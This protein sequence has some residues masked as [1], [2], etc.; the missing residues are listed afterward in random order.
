MAI[1]RLAK[2]DGEYVLQYR[3]YK[4]IDRNPWWKPFGDDYEFIYSEW[5]VVP[6]TDLDAENEIMS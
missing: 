1:L 6:T 4:M 3:T 5:I 2:K